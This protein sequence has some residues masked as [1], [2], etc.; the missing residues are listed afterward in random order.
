MPVVYQHGI[1]CQLQR[2]LHARRKLR[3]SLVRTWVATPFVNI[4]LPSV[5]PRPVSN[6]GLLDPAQT[7]SSVPPFLRH[8]HGRT[9][10]SVEFTVER[11]WG[12]PT[13]MP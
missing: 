13:V 4:N 5:T 2:A 10:G 7:S 6:P 3:C 12:L 8:R 11:P 1:T 9:P